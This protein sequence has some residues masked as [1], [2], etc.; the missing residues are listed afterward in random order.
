[1]K[2]HISKNCGYVGCGELDET[3]FIDN[4]S[5]LEQDL[6]GKIGDIALNNLYNGKYHGI[7]EIGDDEYIIDVEV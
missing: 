1:M 7:F 2:I 5:D 4:I 6:L 3:G